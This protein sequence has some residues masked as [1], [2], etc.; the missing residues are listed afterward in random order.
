MRKGKFSGDCFCSKS[1]RDVLLLHTIISH[2]CLLVLRQ[3]H[4]SSLSSYDLDFVKDHK[5]KELYI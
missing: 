1:S 2:T 3:G 4:L 5:W